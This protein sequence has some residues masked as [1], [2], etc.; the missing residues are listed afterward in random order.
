MADRR[1]DPVEAVRAA[2]K[3]LADAM[4]G[5][6]AYHA[7]ACVKCGLCGET[8]H[9]YRAEPEPENL[10][11]AKADEVIRFYRR[12]HTLAGRLVPGLVGARD[13]T[14]EALDRL[15]EAVYGR[16]T[17]CG[18]CG[19][20][21]SIGLDVASVIGAGRRMLVAAGRVPVV[22]D[23]HELDHGALVRILTEPRN[24]LV[25]QYQT[26]LSV[27]GVDLSFTPGS[28]DAIADEAITRKVGARGL[29]IILEELMLEIMYQIPSL[30]E[31]KELTISKEVVQG[32]VPPLPAVRKV[33]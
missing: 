8:C 19:L 12:Y 17:A 32:R 5:L 3:A 30:P 18:R 6:A 22:A 20:H 9:I 4:R 33:S 21:C 11:A 25:R 13:L 10:P 28:L 24:C 31:L 7:N 27:E 26:V 23:L 2:R 15:V 16:C 14:P 29:R 1:K